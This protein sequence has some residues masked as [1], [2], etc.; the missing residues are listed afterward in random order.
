MPRLDAAIVDTRTVAEARRDFA[1]QLR[2]AGIETPDLDARVLIGHALGLDH[3]ALAAAGARRLDTDEAS[4][5]AALARR[6]LGH[7]P[8]ARIVGQKE[9]WSLPLRIDAA[10]LVPRP[11]SETVVEA[12]LA[13][14]DGRGTR[15]RPLRIAD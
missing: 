14:I 10:T 2:T 8:V 12:S 15:A 11:E 9:F 4:A 7:E 6:R 1:A 5:I 3:A 13:A